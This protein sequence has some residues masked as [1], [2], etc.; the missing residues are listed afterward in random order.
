MVYAISFLMCLIYT[1]IS[2]SDYNSYL[3]TSG[4]KLLVFGVI[5]F[6]FLLKQKRNLS[7][8]LSVNQVKSLR[9]GALLGGVCCVAVLC[10]YTLLYSWFD[11]EQILSGLHSQ[12]ITK[13]VYP[14]VFIHIV[15]INSFLEEFFFR[16]YLF[17]NLYL[18]GKKTA[19]YLVSSL[20]F[21]LYHFGI[22]QSWFSPG[23]VILCLVGLFATG[24]LFCEVDRRADNIYAAWL[25]HLGAN[26][27]IN[28]IGAY[29]FYAH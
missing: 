11:S 16:G 26:I 28:L 2:F 17:R 10:G 9:I 3:I 14:L 13:G 18:S 4:V 20:L 23:L 5:P 12:N 21:S 29:L 15:A 6:L 22:F 24:L 27:G 1:F 19:A 7:Q 25:I 8:I